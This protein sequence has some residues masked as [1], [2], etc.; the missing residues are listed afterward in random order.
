M[1][2]LFHASVLM[3]LSS[4]TVL[5]QSPQ[6]NRIESSDYKALK[7]AVEIIVIVANAAFF[8]LS[9]VVMLAFFKY[10][11]LNSKS[12]Q[13]QKTQTSQLYNT[14]R[15][16]RPEPRS[17]TR[18]QNQSEFTDMQQQ[19]QQQSPPQFRKVYGA[20]PNVNDTDSIEMNNISRSNRAVFN[21]DVD[22]EDDESNE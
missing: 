11:Q 8:L 22:L 19:Q 5:A 10:F 18:V 9:I 20:D 4:V 3:L 14:E 6:I 12:K 13:Q 21:N 2:K 1:N 7:T 16:E 17:T 15:Q